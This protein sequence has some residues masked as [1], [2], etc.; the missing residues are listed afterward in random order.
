MTTPALTFRE[1]D[2]VSG[3]QWRRALAL[4][5]SGQSPAAAAE[6]TEC[7]IVSYKLAFDILPN[8][9]TLFCGNSAPT[10][11]TLLTAMM[12]LTLPKRGIIF[13]HNP[14]SNQEINL[15]RCRPAELRRIYQDVIACWLKEPVL[16]PFLSLEENILLPLK[17][18]L[19]PKTAR[20]DKLAHAI[21]MA[22]LQH[23]LNRLPGSCDPL[24][25]K[26]ATL[27]RMLITSPRILYFYDPLGGLTQDSRDSFLKTLQALKTRHKK[28]L[29]MAVSEPE[30]YLSL[31]D[32][33][34]VLHAGQMRHFGTKAAYLKTRV[35]KQNADALHMPEDSSG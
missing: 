14:I 19:L 31:A 16:M 20:A 5:D 35:S 18:R 8:K 33:V 23:G 6:K 3:R 32:Y 10:L 12:G 4:M 34:G 29:V 28:T 22:G 21:H 9:I 1:V 7:E 26:Q 30:H 24:A 25:L 27:A 13:M 2:L 11:S 15:T 17:F